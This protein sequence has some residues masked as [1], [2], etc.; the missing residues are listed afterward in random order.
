VLR[1]HEGSVPHLSF[2]PDGSWLV[3]GAYDGTR[4]WRLRLDDL[5]QTACA[6]AGRT[7]TPAEVEQYLGGASPAPCAAKGK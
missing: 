5:I 7:L 4:L 6:N 3:S 1:G 2:S